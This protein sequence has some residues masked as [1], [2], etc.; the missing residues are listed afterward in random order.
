MQ[1]DLLWWFFYFVDH[2]RNSC[3]AN[4]YEEA[5]KMAAND[6]DAV[7]KRHNAAVRKAQEHDSPYYANT[8]NPYLSDNQ[9]NLLG[10][11]DRDTIYKLPDYR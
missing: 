11:L 2:M 4:S 1:S 8:G 6:I 10:M 7:I 9:C 3:G 5:L